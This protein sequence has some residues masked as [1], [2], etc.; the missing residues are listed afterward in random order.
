M[1]ILM[2]VPY[3]DVSGPMAR[4]AQLLIGALRGIDCEV[5]TEPWG[6]RSNKE[7][8]WAKIFGRLVDAIRIRR[9]ISSSRP[10]CVLVQTSHEWPSI[11]RDLVLVI[12]IKSKTPSIVL[13]L[14]GGHADRL[15]SP[16]RRIFKHATLRLLRLVDGALVLSSEEVRALE[17]FHPQ[18]RFRLVSNPFKETVTQDSSPKRSRRRTG[19][20]A[21]LLFAG[22]LLSEKG[23]FDAVD[24][25][26]LLNQRRPARLFIAGSGP[27][28]RQLADHILERRLSDQVT[29][30][31][32]LT[33]SSLRQA[34]A[35]ADVFVL[36]TYHPEGF[37]TVIAEAMSAG[38]PIVTTKTRGIADHLEEGVNALFVPPRDATALAQ[39]LEQLLSDKRLRDRMSQANRA[40]VEKFTPEQVAFEYVDALRWI[41]SH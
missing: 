16:G 13:Q 3:S 6:S 35:D 23:V 14:H 7:G 26:G 1:R 27:A 38:L 10:Q 24:A 15:V 9:A 18:G 2:L 39:T 12:A 41:T 8:I 17:T 32:F 36:P 25:V 20:P 31:G 40:T 29:L 5:T 28:E 21:S 4:I 11:L 37:P 19:R 34:Y 22:R 33:P 30:L